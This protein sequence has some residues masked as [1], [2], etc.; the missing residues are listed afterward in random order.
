MSKIL[1]CFQKLTKT[2]TSK[3]NNSGALILLG[4]TYLPRY[5]LPLTGL[6]P[7]STIGNKSHIDKKTPYLDKYVS[8]FI[9][10]ILI[11]VLM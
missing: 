9:Q 3:P 4:S 6:F 11:P 8:N 10:N 7:I 1:T 2:S 5:A